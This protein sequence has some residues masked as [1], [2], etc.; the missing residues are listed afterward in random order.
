MSFHHLAIATKDTK[1]THEFYTKAMGFKLV[2]VELGPTENEGG[3]AKHLFYDTGNGELM[4]FWELHD[5]GI[6]SDWTP[7]ISRGLGLPYWTNH[8]AFG[9]DSLEDLERRKQQWLQ[10]G[11]DCMEID[12]GWCRSIYATDPNRILVEFCVLTREL[13]EADAAEAEQRLY[14]TEPGELPPP[15]PPQIFRASR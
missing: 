5:P 8:I 13:N 15:K 4:A 12:H 7:S 14:A 1:A 9:A 10:N 11:C 6:G 3:W 2:K